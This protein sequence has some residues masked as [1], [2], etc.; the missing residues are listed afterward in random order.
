VRDAVAARLMQI[1][2]AVKDAYAE[3]L[4]LA[5]LTN[6]TVAPKLQSAIDVILKKKPRAPRSPGS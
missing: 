6:G 1:G 2:R 4:D 3:E 5:G